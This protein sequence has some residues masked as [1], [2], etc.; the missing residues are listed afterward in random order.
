MGEPGR[1]LPTVERCLKDAPGFSLHGVPVF[2]GTDTQAF[3]DPGI[4]VSDRG[5]A[6]WKWDVSWGA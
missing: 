2:G 4:E 1:T 6:V 5:S 3:L